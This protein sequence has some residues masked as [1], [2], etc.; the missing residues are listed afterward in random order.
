[1]KSFQRRVGI[2]AL[3]ALILSPVI[4]TAQTAPD[5]ETITVVG[6]GIVAP[7]FE[8]LA[9]ASE[10]GAAINQTITG[11]NSGLEQFCQGQADVATAN[12][13]MTAGED[14][15]CSDGGVDYA[16]LLV[17]HQILAV[18][19]SP[20]VDYVQ[21]LNTTSLNAIFAPSAADVTTNWNQIDVNN[22]DVPLSVFVPGQETAAFAVLDRLISGD[23]IRADATFHSSDSATIAAVASAEGAGAVGVV[24]LASALAAGERVRILDLNTNPVAG[25]AAPSADNV[26]NRLYDAAA[27]LYSYV[28]RASLD[29]PGLRDLLD[30]VIGDQAAAVI[31]AQ[32][33]T[34]PTARTAESSRAALEG[35]Q[36]RPAR[37]AAQY[38]IPADLFGFVAINGSASGRD[39][40]SSITADF[41]ADYPGVTISFETEGDP[42]GF[43]RLCNG[44][45]DLV[46]AASAMN[47][48]QMQNCE[49]NNIT[50][51]P[52]EVGRR[53]VV[54]LANANSDYLSCLTTGQIADIWRAESG[55]QVTTWNQVDASF[56]ETAMT[57]FAPL[58]GSIYTDLMLLAASGASLSNRIDTQINFD[59]LYRA[60][61]TANVEGGLTYMSWAEYQ[62]VVNNNQANIQLV[63]VDGGN[64]CV[65]P[66][67][68]T[69]ADGSYA[70]TG[71]LRLVVNE[72]AL[73]RPEVQSLLWYIFSDQN[74]AY[75][76]QAGLIGLTFGV[77]PEIR[78]A[79]LQAYDRAEAAAAQ[80]PVEPVSEETAEPEPG[81][82]ETAETE[83]TPEA[84]PAD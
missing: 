81:S 74:Y 57:L 37:G 79:L 11:T 2:L 36:E 42:A 53:T 58:A 33:F 46:I 75:F 17:A 4:I 61:A 1:M 49:A 55:G 5:D 20:A 10:T 22:P 59:P 7:L 66:S 12:R 9:A 16:E 13:L 29:K 6:S 44:E 72:A 21:C 48:E 3:L 54:L 52:F 41:S 78:S 31:E 64:G 28:N 8:A 18:I 26:E 56:P 73:I 60:A 32:G 70:L 76:D 67:L 43:R 27:P 50:P 63:R 39:Y 62:R 68:D 24:N 77:L 80:E 25:C 35:I 51:L 38:Q 15:A 84:T 45:L 82:D 14:A 65:E 19:A 30:F 47:T 71:A 40:L 23:G 34:P 83:A 69:I